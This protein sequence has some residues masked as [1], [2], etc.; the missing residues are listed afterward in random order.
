MASETDT[1]DM[2]E[3]IT[4][5]LDLPSEIDADEV[6]ELLEVFQS[7]VEGF[8]EMLLDAV[9]SIEQQQQ[10]PA[11]TSIEQHQQVPPVTTKS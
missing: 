8:D 9:K 10:V 4:F 3:I 1:S 11:V 5:E 7:D 6:L 2:S